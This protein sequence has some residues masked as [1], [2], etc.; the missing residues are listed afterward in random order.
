MPLLLHDARAVTRSEA[1]YTATLAYRPIPSLVVVPIV[2][3]QRV[4]G[5]IVVE[6]AEPASIGVEEAR[7][8]GL[9]A[10]VARAF[11]EKVWEIEEVSQRA[12]TDALTGLA[13]RRHFDEQLRRVIAETD[14]FGGTSSLILVDIDDFKTVND[15]YGH[16]AG[17]AVLRQLG[18]ILGDGVRAVDV[19]ARY[20]GEEMAILLPQTPLAGATELAER[21]R[22]AIADRA[23]L[24]EGTPIR[25]TA[26]FG[27]A[28]YPETVPHGD[29]LFPATDKALYQAK[30][31]GKNRVN[32]VRTSDGLPT[33]YQ[34]G[35][36]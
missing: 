13:N 31:A 14:R 22:V 36:Q 27:I 29:W 1:A 17:D 10:G 24:F 9:L 18:K 12:R 32:A 30:E 28:G 19:C 8:V 5:A 11:L 2:C 7:N 35:P 26:S 21:L 3:E 34:G 4:I 6:G 16:E 23:V 20:G 15:T 33:R 25:V